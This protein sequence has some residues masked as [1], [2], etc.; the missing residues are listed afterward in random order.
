LT[1]ASTIG[2][3]GDVQVTQLTLEDAG[4]GAHGRAVRPARHH[5]EQGQRPPVSSGTD[6]LKRRSFGQLGAGEQ[7]R[8][9]VAASA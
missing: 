5:Q 8:R 3:S 1:V 4:A 6:D 7:A 9:R 2:S